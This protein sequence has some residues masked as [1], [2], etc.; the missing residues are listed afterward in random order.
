[1]NEGNLKRYLAYALGEILL[2]VIGILIAVQLNNWNQKRK[3][4]AQIEA[5][6]DKV[7]EDLIHNV[8][9][10]NEIIDFFQDFDSQ[11]RGVIEGKLT[12]KDYY[13]NDRLGDLYQRFRIMNIV[14]ENIDKLLELEESVPSSYVPIITSAK[15]LR[16]TSSYD[17]NAWIAVRDQRYKNIEYLAS[18]FLW[19]AKSDSSSLEKRYQYFI[20]NPDYKKRVAT[21]WYKV[22][23]MA[24]TTHYHRSITLKMLGIIKMLRHDYSA[25]QLRQFFNS[26]GV[27]SYVPIDCTEEVKRNSQDISPPERMLIANLGSKPGQ[28][29]ILDTKGQLIETKDLDNQE[30]YI[31][32]E[33]VSAIDDDFFTV[34]EWHQNGRCAQKFTETQNGYLIIE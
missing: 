8:K 19:F 23:D 10:T 18:N 34:I 13:H 9:L 33:F 29:R 24:L 25:D 30:Y 17:E 31:Y 32:Q 2:V 6:L 12:K 1:M 4:D 26:V 3:S 14:T 28:L 27:N 22:S 11:A 16:R 21:Y 15:E 20:N 7:E 5:L